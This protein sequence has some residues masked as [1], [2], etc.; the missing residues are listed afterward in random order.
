MS[1]ISAIKA[2]IAFLDSYIEECKVKSL[3]AKR[4]ADELAA[5]YPEAAK[6]AFK[7][8]PCQCAQDHIQEVLDRDDRDYEDRRHRDQCSLYSDSL[9][10]HAR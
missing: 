10:L 3:E 2:R 1:D 7:R 4:R 5:K 6:R 8:L 9:G